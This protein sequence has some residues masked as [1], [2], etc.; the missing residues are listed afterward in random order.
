MNDSAHYFFCPYYHDAS[1]DQFNEDDY[2]YNCIENNSDTTNEEL[3]REDVLEDLADEEFDYDN[4]EDPDSRFHDPV[5][6]EF[7]DEYVDN[8]CYCCN[9]Y[10]NNLFEDFHSFNGNWYE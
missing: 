3:L 7:V 4:Y 6:D 9:D 2:F 10:D 1:E 8:D 5:F